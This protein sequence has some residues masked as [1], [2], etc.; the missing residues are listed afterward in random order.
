M[1]K[2]SKVL[3]GPTVGAGG[4]R[5][6]AYHTGGAGVNRVAKPHETDAT[7]GQRPR[8]WST[9]REGQVEDGCPE[10]RGP[11]PQ[12]RREVE[13]EGEIS[14][15]SGWTPCSWLSQHPLGLILTSLLFELPRRDF[16]C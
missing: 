16:C 14:T 13:P 6:R 9:I 3:E 4:G 2:N 11:V 5:K 8:S 10:V 15:K 12:A 7:G 1:E